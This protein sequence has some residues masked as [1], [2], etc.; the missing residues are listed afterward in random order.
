M[1]AAILPGSAYLDERQYR[2]KKSISDEARLSARTR[3]FSL[4]RARRVEPCAE[5]VS[6]N[7][8]G[9]QGSLV[10][11]RCAMA[12][13]ARAAETERKILQPRVAFHYNDGRA[14]VYI[15]IHT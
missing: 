11:S 5:R 9:G 15:C 10:I 2:E 12:A 13:C 1:A 6:C 7:L 4:A 8:L 14:G 3:E